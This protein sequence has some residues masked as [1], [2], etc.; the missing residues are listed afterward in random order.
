[1]T[2]KPHAMRRVL[3]VG[4]ALAALIAM[5]PDVQ[6]QAPDPNIIWACY[7]PLSGTVYRIKTTD[8]KQECASKSHVMFWFNQ[9]GPQGPQGLQG[10]AG[11]A[12]APGETGA[13]GPQGPPGEGATAYF[14]SLTGSVNTG[15]GLIA[16]SLPAGAYTLLAR[17]RVESLAFGTETAVSC[18]IGAPTE[19]AHTNTNMNRI[20]E[21]GI[22]S[23]VVV[24]VVQSSSPFTAF[25][26]CAGGVSVLGG[27]SLL[28]TKVGSVIVQ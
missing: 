14:K 26:N 7:V 8:T 16:L 4:L 27:T 9:T 3:P 11:A 10:P 2:D 19:I 12:G 13:T 6:A 5:A 20:L 22:T 25:L 15:P 24:G 21:D 1:M 18:N 17:V 23:F 28:A